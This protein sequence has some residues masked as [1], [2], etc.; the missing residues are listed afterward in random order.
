MLKRDEE[1]YGTKKGTQKSSM[2]STI[3]SANTICKFNTCVTFDTVDMPVAFGVSYFDVG[4]IKRLAFLGY[5][6][7][8]YR[9]I[10]I[11]MAVY[12]NLKNFLA[13]KI[14]LGRHANYYISGAYRIWNAPLFWM[15]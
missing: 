9:V 2:M 11:L 5:S 10:T 15:K 8:Q 1:R 6:I 14:W 4:G 12:I 3:P 13:S 7:I